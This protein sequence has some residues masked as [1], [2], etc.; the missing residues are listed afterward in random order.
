MNVAI[1]AYDNH[2]MIPARSGGHRNQW[3]VGFGMCGA[4]IGN[5][6]EQDNLCR[7]FLGLI[8]KVF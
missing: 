5:R 3:S 8:V 4:N 7:R 1:L 2:T 6:A